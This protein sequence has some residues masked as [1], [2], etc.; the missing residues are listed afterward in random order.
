M[1]SS[2]DTGFKRAMKD[3]LSG[4]V[5]GFFQVIGGHPLDL[6][7][8][9]LQTQIAGQQQFNGMVDCI[10]KTFAQEGMKAF[11]KG[12]ASPITGAMAMNAGLFFSY[13]QARVY[14]ADPQKPNEPLSLPRI[15]LAGA[16]AGGFVSLIES[17]FDLVKVKL[18]AQ[19]GQGAY[20]GV[21]DAARKIIGQHG[22]RGLYQGVGATAIRDI[23]AFGLYFWS[24]EAASRYLSRD[25]QPP[26]LAAAA[27]AGGVGGF[28]FW[29][30]VYP[31][32]II[33]TRI[34][35]DSLDPATRQYRGW[36]DCWNKTLASE[37]WR[38]LFK[39]YVPC[40]VRAVPVNMLLFA[41]VA[42]SQKAMN[43]K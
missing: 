12:A 19:V 13:G 39:G 27:I 7:K 4:T 33:K 23:P 14:L 34:Q 30:L 41:A 28:G 5:G 29:G 32:E 3:I 38:G 36:V 16:F 42:A 15:L 18:Q 21:F 8:V 26:S 2:E 35:N 40:N 22:I 25:G 31:T 20:T 37:G 6:V 10:K 17:P 11:Y 1:A 9:R 24:F 43:S